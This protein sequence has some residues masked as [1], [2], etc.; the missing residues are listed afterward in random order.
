MNVVCLCGSF[1]EIS[2]TSDCKITK[3]IS[4]AQDLLGWINLKHPPVSC[5]CWKRCRLGQPF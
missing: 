4:L 1:E 5:E 2:V 3:L